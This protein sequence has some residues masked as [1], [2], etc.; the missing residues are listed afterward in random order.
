MIFDNTLGF[1]F[2]SYEVSFSLISTLIKVQ[3]LIHLYQKKTFKHVITLFILI[4][5]Y[6]NVPKAK[7]RM[8]KILSSCTCLIVFSNQSLSEMSTNLSTMVRKHSCFHSDIIL[9]A[10][11][12]ISGVVFNIPCQIR[13]KSRKLKT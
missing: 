5:V 7:K 6:D 13:L 11:L 12:M 9:P 2:L 3:V 4:M 10:L 8:S 1:F